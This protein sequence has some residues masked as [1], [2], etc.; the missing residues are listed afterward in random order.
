MSSGSERLQNSAPRSRANA[1][2]S[3]ISNPLKNAY[4]WVTMHAMVWTARLVSFALCSGI[5]VLAVLFAR[6]RLKDPAAGMDKWFVH[7]GRFLRGYG[8]FSAGMMLFVG[9]AFCISGL[10][11]LLAPK[12]TVLAFFLA[13]P[14]SLLLR[15]KSH[16]MD[17]LASPHAATAPW[18]AGTPAPATTDSGPNRGRGWLT[19]RGKWTLGMV[20]VVMIALYPIVDYS[21]SQSEPFRLAM[22]AVNANGDAI[23]LLGAHIERRRWAGISGS[24]QTQGSNGTAELS[25]PV[26]GPR[27]K[28]TVTVYA[29][30]RADV[31]TI[32]SLVL[33]AADS[34]KSLV[35]VEVSEKDSSPI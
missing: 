33:K 19:R 14:V 32:Q 1:T 15:P 17:V 8:R 31:W 4:H 28:G 11:C 24:M 12:L 7:P 13:M 29:V 10:F 30:K 5:G 3:E 9:S 18:E 23:G 2:D 22:S 6:E 25:I 35:L 20:L 34:S 16:G 26:Q 27:G 21:F